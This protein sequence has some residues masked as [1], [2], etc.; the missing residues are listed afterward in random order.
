[1]TAL[2]KAT[3]I[4]APSILGAAVTIGLIITSLNLIHRLFSNASLPSNLPWAGVGEHNSRLGRAKA[5]I[6]SFFNLRKLL[7]EGYEKV[8]SVGRFSDF[9]SSPTCCLTRQPKSQRSHPSSTP[10]TTRRTS[11][12]TSSTAHRW[13]SRR[14]R[15]RGFWRNPTTC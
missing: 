3:F 8:S 2:I 15:S 13:S 5:N 4:A 10:R 12:P 9:Y 6:T 1:M 7:D 11:Y 14:L